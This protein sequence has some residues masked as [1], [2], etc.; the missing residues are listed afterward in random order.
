MQIKK[1]VWGSWEVVRHAMFI[2]DGT[3]GMDRDG[4]LGVLGSAQE[5]LCRLEMTHMVAVWV[6]KGAQVFSRD[7]AQIR[8]GTWGSMGQRGG[9][10]LQDEQCGFKKAHGE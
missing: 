9:V 6:M 3:Q 7:V 4:C 5:V 10:G 1:N 8:A 2:G